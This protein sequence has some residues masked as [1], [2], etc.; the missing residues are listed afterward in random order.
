MAAGRAPAAS[1]RARNTDRLSRAKRHRDRRRRADDDAAGKSAVRRADHLETIVA[2]SDAT[3]A[4]LATRDLLDLTVRQLEA[5]IGCDYS[6]VFEFEPDGA[7]FRLVAGAGWQPGVVGR[8]S[9]PSG[10]APFGMGRGIAVE[11]EAVAED[12]VDGLPKFMREHGIRSSVSAVIPNGSHRPFGVLAVHARTPASFH[13]RD[14]RLVFAAAHILGGSLNAPGASHESPNTHHPSAAPEWRERLAHDFRSPLA[15]ARNAVELL[16]R[17]GGLDRGRLLDM[18]D[19]QVEALTTA[20]DELRGVVHRE[21]GDHG[22]AHAAP[23]HRKHRILVVDDNADACESLALLLR[24]HGHEV[25]TET[26]AHGVPAL[27]RR[28]QPD[29]VLLDLG[30]PGGDGLQVC[31]QL[32]H[33]GHRCAIA[34]VTGFDQEEDRRATA[35]AGFDRHLVKPLDPASLGALVQALVAERRA[36]AGRGE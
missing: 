31:R 13:G 25:V 10:P 21:S 5:A 35:A 11:A 18:I 34:A 2:L 27:A 28:F 20:V 17:P 16:R 3:R 6:S 8:A 33:A 19:H 4:G 14:A 22:T 1:P 12:R 29:L 9:V 32:R 24:R 26:T 30:L 7:C 36:S 15:A 23:A